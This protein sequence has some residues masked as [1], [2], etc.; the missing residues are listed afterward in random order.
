[1]EMGERGILMVTLWGGT[2]TCAWV[3]KGGGVKSVGQAGGGSI[4]AVND[5]G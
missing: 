2:R 5:G 3:G 1:M 4:I